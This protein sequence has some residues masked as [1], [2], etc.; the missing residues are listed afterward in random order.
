MNYLIYIYYPLL[1]L[2]ILWGCKWFPKG[3]WNEEALSIKQTKALQGF[4]AVCIMLHHIG[5]K[6]C[7]PW[8]P[9][10]V[11][12]HGLD[13][14]VPIGYLLVGIFLFCSGFGLYKSYAENRIIYKVS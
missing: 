14:F 6:T 9:S 4:C 8:L 2:L 5:Q 11:I 7:A 12:T 13:A 10:E 1:I 3:H